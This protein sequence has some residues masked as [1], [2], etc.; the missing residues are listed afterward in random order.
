MKLANFL[1]S[2]GCIVS[3]P[4][5][6]AVLTPLTNSEKPNPQLQE[7]IASAKTKSLS[8]TFYGLVELEQTHLLKVKAQPTATAKA[9]KPFPQTKHTR[10][11]QTYNGLPV[12]GYQIISHEKAGA[13]PAYSGMMV[14]ELEKDLTAKRSVT[15]S[16]SA[17]YQAKKAQYL[18]AHPKA[19]ISEY[20]NS[21]ET[22]I[23]IDDKQKAH[24][25]YHITFLAVDGEKNL[26]ERSH[27][28]IDVNSNTEL[29]AWNGLTTRGKNDKV[30][31]QRKYT[32]KGVAPGGNEKI[33]FYQYGSDLEPLT[34]AYIVNLFHPELTCYL[35]N[36]D[37]K[38]MD[39]QSEWGW[40]SGVQPKNPA[41]LCDLSQPEYPGDPVNGAASPSSDALAFGTFVM[42]EYFWWDLSPFPFGAQKLVMNVHVGNNMIN[43]FWDGFAVS[44][45]DGD[46]DQ[47]FYPLVTMDIVGHEISHGFTE[48]TSNLIYFGQFGG[49]NE[50][51]SDIIG[52]YSEVKFNHR[53]FPDRP[54]TWTI[55]DM[56]L[57]EEDAALRYMDEPR[58]TGGI[59]H[60]NQ[61]EDN[62]DVHKSSGL[63]N[64]VFYLIATDPRI[65]QLTTKAYA[66]EKAAEIFVYTNMNYWYPLTDFTHAAW[67]LMQA[68]EEFESDEEQYSAPYVQIVQDALEKV[69]IVCQIAGCYT[70][71]DTKKN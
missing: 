43:A 71:D 69:G 26:V 47:G 40:G 44:F 22:V 49:L 66:I 35:D 20:P 33:G 2:L 4:V 37:V 52:K 30:I 23:F 25:A 9:K 48:N 7:L 15:L 63:F 1:L 13:A 56:V 14:S 29:K 53:N 38:I 59:D 55:G 50:S 65:N 11:Q 21:K 27:W 28:I 54:I 62:L 42:N 17:A 32:N 36:R 58:R 31:P 45:G 19:V 39:F 24:E 64:R 10:Y 34:F 41:W 5:S 51:F 18:K 3:M 70:E 16:A 60:I 57:V 8:S 68:A 12:F 46:L 67:G 6:A 61:Y